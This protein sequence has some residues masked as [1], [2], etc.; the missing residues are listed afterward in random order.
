MAALAESVG[1]AHPPLTLEGLPLPITMRFREPLT[2]EELIAFSARIEPYR[3]ERN[4]NGELEI[5][6]PLVFGGGRRESY[7]IGR[8]ELWTELHG[9][10]SFSSGTGFKLPD[11]SMRCPD[12]AWISDIRCASLAADDIDRIA[13]ICPDFVVEVLSKTDRRVTLESKMESWIANGAQLA[14]MIDPFAATVSIYRPNTAAEIL[15]R[16]NWVEADTIVPGFRLE[17][18]RLWAK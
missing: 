12:A 7:V 17:T 2:D 13:P 11:G 15:T 8:L 1:L 10:A 18:S 16:P 4:E 6:T 3:I 9:G 14:W 5:M